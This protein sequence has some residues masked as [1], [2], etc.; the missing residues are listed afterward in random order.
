MPDTPNLYVSYHSLYGVEN[1]ENYTKKQLQTSC[2]VIIQEK[3]K[4]ASQ[5]YGLEV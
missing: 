2:N 1:V 3:K 4:P 5:G